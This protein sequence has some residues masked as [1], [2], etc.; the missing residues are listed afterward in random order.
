MSDDKEIKDYEIM[1]RDMIPKQEL[2]AVIECFEKTLEKQKS[3][4]SLDIISVFKQYEW[5][6]RGVI[7]YRVIDVHTPLAGHK[8]FYAYKD[9]SR[10]KQ[11]N[12][13]RKWF[14]WI[15]PLHAHLDYDNLP[16]VKITVKGGFVEPIDLP[17]G[18]KWYILFEET[19]GQNPNLMG[20]T[21]GFLV[22]C[23][24][25][26][27]KMIDGYVQQIAII[28][29][30]METLMQESRKQLEMTDEHIENR[31]REKAQQDK[32][33]MDIMNRQPIQPMQMQQKQD[34]KNK[35]DFII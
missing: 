9:Y 24:A 2:K 25:K 27:D 33:V 34:D 15:T 19:T 17:E 6:L 23:M 30:H 11:S 7:D 13:P 32:A 1:A 31:M 12:Y 18:L 29:E 22:D 21:L 16:I 20:K 26:K 3:L 5:N 35:G 14:W 10:L 4:K 28:R 8:V